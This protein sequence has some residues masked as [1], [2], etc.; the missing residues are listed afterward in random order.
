MDAKI[1]VRLPEETKRRMEAVQAL[2]DATPS[3]VVRMGIEA[4][5]NSLI[6]EQPEVAFSGP[7]ET[8]AAKWVIVKAHA[9]HKGLAIASEEAGVTRETAQFWLDTDP[10]FEQFVQAAWDKSIELADYK[11]W[12]IGYNEENIKALFGILNAQHPDYGMVKQEYIQGKVRQM[13]EKEILPLV[14]A[15]LSRDDLASL[16]RELSAIFGIPLLEGPGEGGS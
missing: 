8:V 6:V 9:S 15:R 10:V 11:L 4:L 5:H 7:P 16:R 12:H 14:T 3:V 2:L 13:L 1:S